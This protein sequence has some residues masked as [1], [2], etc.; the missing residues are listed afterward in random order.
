M[1]RLAYKSFTTSTNADTRLWDVVQESTRQGVRE[2][3]LVALANES[4][5]SARHKVSDAIAE[6]AR[7]DLGEG[8]KFSLFNLHVFW[9][10]VYQ[11]DI[12][13][14]I[15]K[16]DNLL[17]ALFDCT[18]SPNAAHRESAF[19]IFATVP[20]LIA[21]QHTDALKNVFMTSLT[22]SE[23]QA[24]SWILQ[25]EVCVTCIKV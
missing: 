7:Y 24:V 8:S 6:V 11:R 2:L 22:D 9:E 18:Q 1:R 23:S 12:S 3:L 10:A 5:Q 15:D 17:K 21:G 4:D 13:F 16:W 19:R 25:L 20:D 14:P